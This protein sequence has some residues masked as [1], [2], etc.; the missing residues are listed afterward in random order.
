MHAASM[1]QVRPA[2]IG[3]EASLNTN[4]HEICV[5]RE[6]R[7]VDA[8]QMPMRCELHAWV[9]R[10]YLQITLKFYASMNKL[11]ESNHCLLQKSNDCLG[12]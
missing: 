4:N 9:R 8:C 11:Q 7:S 6:Y 5:V 2:I 10:R 3:S 1:P 12:I